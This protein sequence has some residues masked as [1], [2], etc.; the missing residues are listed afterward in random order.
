MTTKTERATAPE[1]LPLGAFGRVLRLLAGG[2][3]RHLQ[4]LDLSELTDEQLDDIGISRR[5]A[6]RESAKPFWR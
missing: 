1:R 6:E 2:Y 5:D 4:R 3:D